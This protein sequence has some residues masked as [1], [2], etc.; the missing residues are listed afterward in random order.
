MGMLLKTLIRLRGHAIM[1]TFDQAAKDP[2]RAQAK[3]LLNIVKH[4][5]A[6]EYGRKYGF[7]RVNDGDSFATAVP[8]NAFSDL[9]PYV[10]KMK[11]GQK[12]ILT[13]DP[14]LMFCVTSGTS[15]SPKFLPITRQGRDTADRLSYQW[16]SRA[17][18]SH[19]SY[20]DH[21]ICLISGA[22][23]EGTTPSGIPYGS[24][25]GMMYEGLPRIL[26]RSFVLP[27]M[28]AK[29]KDYDLRYYL[30]AILAL[31]REVSFIVTPNPT[32]LI[33]VAETAICHQDEIVRSI[34]DGSI[35]RT[36]PLDSSSGDAGILKAISASLIPDRPRARFLDTVIRRHGKLLPRACWKHLKLIGCWLGGS[37]GFQAEKLSPYYGDDV[38]TRDIGYLASEG[39]MTL[40]CE[41]NTPA[42]VLAIF[43]NY[44][45]F[46]PEGESG[47]PGGPVLRC[48]ELELGT[49]YKIIL[50][51]WNGLYRYNIDDVI[52]VRGFYKETPVVAF[53]R[54]GDDVLNITGEKVHVNHLIEAFRRLQAELNVTVRQFRVVPDFK[55]VRYAILIYFEPGL[56][57][58]YLKDAVL[59][60]IDKA[61]C[62]MNIEYDSK[63]K[64]KRLLPPCIHVMAPSWEETVR[65][66]FLETGRRDIQYKWRLTAP[67]ITK[68]DA[69][70]LQDTIEM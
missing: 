14:P 34:H 45:E 5:Q 37:V 24:A 44:F 7:S 70:H 36:W 53:V 1:R 31:S 43:N 51:N 39:S 41:D 11:N 20:L 18:L 33:R 38:P 6:T 25:S 23:T 52:E 17:L 26:R 61:L 55:K 19:P 15:G 68:L 65:R 40:P 54:K 42:G 30:T 60:F 47:I 62:E 63:R 2:R 69:K 67:E 12:D 66:H 64:S 4:N 9:S 57:K 22:S 56:S 8:V 32:T 3:L 59:P 10:E 50:T 58:G 46:I 29:I 28:L 16:L 13:A 27:F 49:R 21:S 48:H 35:S